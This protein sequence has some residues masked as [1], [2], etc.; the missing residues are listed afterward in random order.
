[1]VFQSLA[2]NFEEIT[3]WIEDFIPLNPVDLTDLRSW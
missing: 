1:M 3:F 2:R